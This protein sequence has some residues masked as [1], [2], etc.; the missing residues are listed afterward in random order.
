MN[1]DYCVFSSWQDL[2]D[3][4]FQGYCFVGSDFVFGPGGAE[5]FL[6]DGGDLRCGE[7]GCYLLFKRQ[8]DL[9]TI[10]SD[11]S[12]HMRLFYFSDG[13]NWAVSNSF[14]QLAHHLKDHGVRLNIQKAHLA[15]WFTRSGNF[16]Q[17]LC[18][19]T[20]IKEIR[21]LPSDMEVNISGGNFAL[22][23][24]TLPLASSYAS[25]LHT[26]LTGWR[27]RTATILQSDVCS[28][29][30]DVSGGLDTR[31]AIGFLN[32]SHEDT[33]RACDPDTT[34]VTTSGLYFEKDEEV[35]QLVANSLGCQLERQ[36]RLSDVFFDTPERV[37]NIWRDRNLGQYATVR[38]SD[39]RLD[40]RKIA[41][42]GEAGEVLRGIYDQTSIESYLK[43]QKR[44]YGTY[45]QGNEIQWAESVRVSMEALK[46]RTEY[47]QDPL[48]GYFRQYR[49]RCHGGNR[50]RS[51]VAVLPLT[52]EAAY[53]CTAAL[54][55]EAVRAGQLQYDTMYN[56]H[57]ELIDLPFDEDKKAPSAEVR[58]NLTRV[59]LSEAVGGRFY[60]SQSDM[61][62]DV[63]GSGS[64]LRD[65]HRYFSDYLDSMIADIPKNVISQE[66]IDEAVYKFRARGEG[67]MTMLPNDTI[68]AHNLA[69]FG[70]LMQV[71]DWPESRGLTRV[72]ERFQHWTRRKK[73]R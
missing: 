39:G 10:G 31:T 7:D 57:S 22:R 34:Y 26:Y 36:V 63:Q 23:T 6:A 61:P 43:R 72:K 14:I 59:E 1:G 35:S 51:T 9:I 15:A 47:Y 28:V 33:V 54:K 11:F 67:D 21:F 71:A 19:E 70:E 25:A 44:S 40:P 8:G 13:E 37:F 17:L 65:V 42:C 45:M 49:S 4:H 66:H 73:R 62:A 46:E 52:G 60:V 53:R 68:P 5:Q 38:F 55:N 30:V 27:N 32:V 41:I 12:G 2:P 18:E 58:A 3:F 50:P 69:L 20:A 64:G 29:S 16:K 48:L 56:L 24:H